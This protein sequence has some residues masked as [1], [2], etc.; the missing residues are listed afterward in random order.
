MQR[1][2][3]RIRFEV[4]LLIGGLLFLCAYAEVQ[5]A[6]KPQRFDVVIYGGTSSGVM[7]AVQA[8]RMGR[9]AMIV[10]PDK[11]LG[12]LTSGGLGWTDTGNKAVIGGLARE[13]YHRVW[14]HYQSV[15]AWKWQR[16]EEYGNKGQATP[17]VDG[18]QRTMWI[19]EPHVAE[20]VFDQFVAEYDIPVFRDEWLDRESGV[21]SRDGCIE[22][23][24]MLSGR[25]VHG[26]SFID[27]TYEG[28]LMAAAGVAFHVGRESKAR[29]GEEWNGIQTGVLHHG[30][31]FGAVDR[32]ISPYVIPDDP[33]SGLLPRI[34]PDPPGSTRIHPVSTA[35]QTNGYRPTA[36]GCVSATILEIESRFRSRTATTPVSMNCCSAFWRP[37]GGKGSASSIRSPITKRIPTITVRSAPTTSDLITTIRKHRMHAVDRL[38]V[39]MKSIS[40]G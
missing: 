38:F 16:R 19:F 30:H 24:R 13:F 17:A 25:T 36:F 9:T 32:P 18:Q 6:E 12:G 27:A 34:S 28:D 39:S 10:C 3:R 5:A 37:A 26:R 4:C 33:S 14:R 2:A 23:I 21:V 1:T 40:R 20:Q 31:H 29:Y 35:Q 7:A 22:S 8:R 11:H 15:D